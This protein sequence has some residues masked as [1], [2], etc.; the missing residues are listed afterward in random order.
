MRVTTDSG[1]KS[2]D[3]ELAPFCEHYGHL[4]IHF[5]H[6]SSMSFVDRLAYSLSS[7]SPKLQ[8]DS[9]LLHAFMNS[10]MLDLACILDS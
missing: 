4:Q 7:G 5:V 10:R 6:T 2:T 1:R 9:H 3:A 8:S